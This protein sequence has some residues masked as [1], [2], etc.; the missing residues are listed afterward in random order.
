[1]KIPFIVTNNINCVAKRAVRSNKRPFYI[2][3]SNTY[4]FCKRKARKQGKSLCGSNC[5]LVKRSKVKGHLNKSVKINEIFL[6]YSIT[7]GAYCAISCKHEEQNNNKGTS[8]T[9][10]KKCALIADNIRKSY[11]ASRSIGPRNSNSGIQTNAGKFHALKVKSFYERPRLNQTSAGKIH[12]KVSIQAY[13]VS[14]GRGTW[15]SPTPPGAGS[16]SLKT[17]WCL[18]AGG[19][20]GCVTI[21]VAKLTTW[22]NATA[23]SV[24]A[25]VT[26]L[27]TR[28][29]KREI[30]YYTND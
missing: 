25:K 5:G 29:M 9:S 23:K 18:A 15:R 24:T 27:T 28:V 2:F 1:V 3:D 13:G 30:N 22:V 16:L 14:R 11:D 8:V 21:T 26:Y 4:Y 10:G 7:S 20:G 19:S 6:R 12:A 17:A